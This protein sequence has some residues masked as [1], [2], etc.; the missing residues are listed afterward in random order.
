M[1]RV[2]ERRPLFFGLNLGNGF[3][4]TIVGDLGRLLEIANQDEIAQRASACEGELFSVGRPL[5]GI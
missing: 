1:M 5:K 2:S 3:D 4:L